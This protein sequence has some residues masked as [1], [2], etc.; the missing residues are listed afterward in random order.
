MATK[1]FS[2]KV[3]CITVNQSVNRAQ[4]VFAEDVKQSNEKGATAKNVVN[5]AFTDPKEAAAFVP[6]ETYTIEISK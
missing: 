1:K 3:E 6:G 4:V 2:K 5:I